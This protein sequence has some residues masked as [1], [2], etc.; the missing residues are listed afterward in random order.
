MKKVQTLE[1]LVVLVGLPGAGK[2]SLARK[3]GKK[4]ECIELDNAFDQ[5]FKNEKK[6][7]GE[8]GERVMKKL[9]SKSLVIDDTN[10][11]RSMRHFWFSIAARAGAVCVFVWVKTPFEECQKRNQLRGNRRVPDHSMLKINENFEPPG[12]L[13]FEEN[14]LEV[15][16]E[17]DFA[18]LEE[19]TKPA[20]VKVQEKQ[21]TDQGERHKID[22][23]LRAK[24]AETMKFCADRREMS[25]KLR[26]IKEEILA[27][28]NSCEEADLL[29]QQMIKCN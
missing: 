8:I 20:V 28:A 4:F 10:H 27:T 5:D 15:E 9:Q 7:R 11:L 24:V 13:Y 17:I 3:F 16:E 19:F 18:S 2:S 25:K 29:F 1:M 6:I 21:T 12:Q 22:Q 14:L 23:F 26:K